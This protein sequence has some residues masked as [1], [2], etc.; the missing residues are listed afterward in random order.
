MTI[1]VLNR[2]RDK[3][4]EGEDLRRVSDEPGFIKLR[5]WY[6]HV[7][8]EKGKMKTEVES[9]SSSYVLR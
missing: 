6:F 4:D 3:Y 1:N 8:A 7:P 5:T 2:N 9:P